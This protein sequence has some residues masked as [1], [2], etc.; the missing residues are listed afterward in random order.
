MDFRIISIGTLSHHPLWN[1][2][3]PVRVPHATTTLI[4]SGDRTILVDPALPEQVLAARLNE[5]SGLKPEAVT[6]IF[7]TSFRPT[8]RGGLRLFD[9]ARWW[10]SEA[11][12]ETIG[13]D[14]VRKLSEETDEETQQLLQQE[15][16]ILQATKAAED[17]FAEHVDLFPLPGYSVGTCG[18]LLALPASTVIVAGDAVPTVEHFER[19][20]VLQGAYDVKLARESM[21][22]VIEIADW[23]IPGHDNLIPNA[24]RRGI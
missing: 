1:E 7:L 6:D 5:R 21:A 10:I 3:Q 4:R 2:G 15:I 19:G 18:L 16:A 11:E 12:R 17:K 9:H 22:E 13:V 8:H 23:V 20:Q 14:L 24:T